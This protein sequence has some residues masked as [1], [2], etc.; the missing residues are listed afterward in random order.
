M[1]LEDEPVDLI[2]L[3]CVKKK[4]DYA[5]PARDVY[6]S[7]LWVYRRKYAESR[8]RAW[9]ILS[10]KH[11]LLASDD[12]IDP[13]DLSLVNLPAAKRRAWSQRVLNALKEK[14]PE[15]RGKIIEIH[16]GKPYVEY[17]L[18]EGLRE[19]GVKVLRPL[20][21]ERQGQQIKWYKDYLN[22]SSQK[23]TG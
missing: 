6:A 14:V 8:G 16:A 20:E 18:E 12:W 17:G 22:S 5:G 19:A 11:G 9:Y 13:Y 10:A 7:P 15:L 2:L 3:G 23:S 4:R 21:H 1:S